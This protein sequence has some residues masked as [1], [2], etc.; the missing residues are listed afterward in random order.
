[1]N[2]GLDW[3]WVKILTNLMD[4]IGLDWV[5]KLV[6]WVGLD[7]E[8][9]THGHLWVMV[10]M[11]HIIIIIIII[12]IRIKL[13]LNATSGLMLLSGSMRFHPACP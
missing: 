6:D 5:S 13:Y 12:I 2:T 11:L 7:L 10:M 1:M 3:M 8:K 4:W 9:W